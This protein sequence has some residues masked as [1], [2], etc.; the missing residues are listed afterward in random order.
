MEKE[1]RRGKEETFCLQKAISRFPE[2][3]KMLINALSREPENTVAEFR[4]CMITDIAGSSLSIPRYIPLRCL[5]EEEE[6]RY[7]LKERDVLKREEG[8][9][10]ESPL[11]FVS[12]YLSQANEVLSKSL[13]SHMESLL[14]VQT[15]RRPKVKEDGIT[16]LVTCMA[17]HPLCSR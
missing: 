3:A 2:I 5:E 4:A 17:W 1:G 7:A 11:S 6:G 16:P 13:L 9:F 12:S 14:G 8:E 15:T 10:K